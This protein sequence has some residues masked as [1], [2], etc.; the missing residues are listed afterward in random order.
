MKLLKFLPLLSLTLAS[1][2]TQ[3][4][5]SSSPT[6]QAAV[7]PPNGIEIRFIISREVK[8]ESNNIERK[9]YENAVLMAFGETETA[10]FE[11]LFKIG[12]V[13]TDFGSS[14]RVKVTLNDNMLDGVLVGSDVVDVPFGG[15]STIS[16]SRPNATY[17]V[18][19]KA[20]RRAL[21]IVAKPT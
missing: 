20:K 1:C 6:P 2:A 14:A 17:S 4:P 8:L 21:S 15:Q 19:L 3:L 16:L 5:Q 11:K 13:A 9:S 18:L 12:L 10:D 7:V